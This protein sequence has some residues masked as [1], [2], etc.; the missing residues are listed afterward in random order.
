MSTHSQSRGRVNAVALLVVGL[1]LFAIFASVGTAVIAVTRG[2][3]PLPDQYHWE[4]DTLDHD[5]ASSRRATEL[6]LQARLELQP[7]DGVC[8]LS[9]HLKAALPTAV[10]VNLV[11]GS[12]AGLDRQIRFLQTASPS[13]YLAPCP[14][15]PTG[16]WHIELKDPKGA[17]SFRQEWSGKTPFVTMSAAGQ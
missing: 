2:D 1:P 17:W 5:F 4:G 12:R 16:Q 11:H 15:M 13:S 7:V 14:A 10:D 9:L 8:H 6:G 3:P